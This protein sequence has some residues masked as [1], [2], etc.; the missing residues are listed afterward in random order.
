M[1]ETLLERLKELEIK[2]GREWFA[3]LAK[4]IKKDPQTIRRWIRSRS[5]PKG[6]DAYE[7]ALA[8]GFNEEDA[9][10]LA[11]ECS[12]DEATESAPKAVKKS[13]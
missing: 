5:I 8:C 4:S 10:R 1:S 13:A 2:K 12:S 11:K 7:L 9:L 3:D 6:H